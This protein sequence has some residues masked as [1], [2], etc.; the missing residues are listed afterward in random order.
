MPFHSLEVDDRRSYLKLPL[1]SRRRAGKAFSGIAA[2]PT[3][4]VFRL[5]AFAVPTGIALTPGCC[6]LIVVDGPL[7]P[8]PR[9]DSL[10]FF[11]FFMSRLHCATQNVGKPAYE[12]QVYAEHP[13]VNFTS[14][15][16]RIAGKTL[17][18]GQYT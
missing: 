15:S 17:F 2:T 11:F 9:K 5:T 16:K 3:F 6:G 8:P 1:K 4:C 18:Q 10:F 12:D 14:K 13:K 7:P